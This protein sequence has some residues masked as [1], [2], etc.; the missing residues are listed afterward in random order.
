ML[1]CS[2]QMLLKEIKYISKTIVK[3]THQT[4]CRSRQAGVATTDV[5]RHDWEEVRG[6]S[7]DRH[8]HRD[9]DVGGRHRD[10]DVGRLEM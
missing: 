6:M 5:A 9:A 1:T 10:M 7:A 3:T 2:P 4:H 8:G